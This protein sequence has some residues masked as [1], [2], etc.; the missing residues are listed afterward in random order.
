MEKILSIGSNFTAIIGY[1]TAIIT[2]LTVTIK[3]LRQKLRN[4]LKEESN[5]KELEK[6]IDLL[7]DMLREHIRKDEEKTEVLNK[8]SKSQLCMMRNSITEC[9]YRYR[10]MKQLPLHIREKLIKEYEDYHSNN[11]NTYI[12]VIYPEMLEWEVID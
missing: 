10:D 11:G 1:L 4:W 5:T 6:K 9:Y 3:P 2:F 7:S 12:D 8:L